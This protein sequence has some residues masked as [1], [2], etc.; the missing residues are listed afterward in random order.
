[1]TFPPY[2]R[3]IPLSNDLCD[4]SEGITIPSLYGV[5]EIVASQAQVAELEK[6]VRELERV[7]E[8]LTRQLRRQRYTKA[9][10]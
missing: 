6:E 2:G 7:V 10:P 9:R 4:N 1:M 8:K 3:P 5:V